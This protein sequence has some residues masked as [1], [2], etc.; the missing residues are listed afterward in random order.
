M[1]K[2]TAAHLNALYRRL[3]A[4][5]SPGGKGPLAP[6]TIREI[7]HI[8][9]GAYYTAAIRHDLVLV[10][11]TRKADPPT[12]REIRA[13]RLAARVWTAAASNIRQSTG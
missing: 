1:S 5:G 2:L 12:E 9:S 10:S 11:P 13:S 7:H 3:A 6:A 4:E 8:I